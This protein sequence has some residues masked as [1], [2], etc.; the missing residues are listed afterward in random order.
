MTPRFTKQLTLDGIP[1]PEKPIKE[2]HAAD[3]I[4][5]EIDARPWPTPVSTAPQKRRLQGLTRIIER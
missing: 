1:P 2:A 3:L 4:D 5:F